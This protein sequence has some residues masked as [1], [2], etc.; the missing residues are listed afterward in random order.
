MKHAFLIIAHS[1][2][3]LLSVLVNLL[4]HPNNDIYILIDKKA[5]LPSKDL[6]TVNKSNLFLLDKK[7][8]GDE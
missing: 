4:D 8:G 5:S 1:Q 6:L 2:Y 7:W 3:E